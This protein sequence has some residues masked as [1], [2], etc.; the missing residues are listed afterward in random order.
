[1]RV[2]DVEKTQLPI[3][4]MMPQTVVYINNKEV[5]TFCQY[6]LHYVQVAI[7][8]PKTEVLYGGISYHHMHGEHAYSLFMAMGQDRTSEIRPPADLLFIPHVIYEHGEPF[9]I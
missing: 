8:N 2:A 3:E 1:V 5:C 9:I 4:R 6:F 7:T